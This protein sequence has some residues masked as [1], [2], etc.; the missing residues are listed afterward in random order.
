VRVRSGGEKVRVC[1]FK[2]EVR[3]RDRMPTREIARGNEVRRK[4]RP[5]RRWG[6]GGN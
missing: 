1:V 6:G 4:G 2:R 3:T 5:K